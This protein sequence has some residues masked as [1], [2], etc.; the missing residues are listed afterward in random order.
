MRTTQMAQSHNYAQCLVCKWDY[1]CFNNSDWREAI[2]KHVKE[3]GHKVMRESNR[4]S[5]YEPDGPT[6]ED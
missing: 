1:D 2:R 5:Y 4:V 6:K 3:T